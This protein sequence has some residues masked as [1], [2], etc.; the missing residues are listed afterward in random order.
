MSVE[1]SLSIRPNGKFVNEFVKL[2]EEFLMMRFNGRNVF[3]IFRTT[4]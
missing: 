4:N 1:Q 3:G 2:P